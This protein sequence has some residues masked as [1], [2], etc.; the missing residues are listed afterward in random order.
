MGQRMTGV[1]RGWHCCE[2]FLPG[3]GRKKEN[4]TGVLRPA[5]CAE[6]LQRLG[7]FNATQSGCVR[8][9]AWTAG[10]LRLA[11][12]SLPHP[13]KT[14]SL[15]CLTQHSPLIHSKNTFRVC[16]ALFEGLF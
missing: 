15:P 4:K 3:S 6:K 10:V 12:M 5:G 2:Q 1:C 11:G 8:Y 16:T 9:G 13:Y 7:A 14:G